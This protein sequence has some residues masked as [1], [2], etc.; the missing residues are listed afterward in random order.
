M[1]PE[2]ALTIFISAR[3]MSTSWIISIQYTSSHNISEESYKKFPSLSTSS[4]SRCSLSLMFP[5]QNSVH[6]SAIP[7]RATCLTHLIP[8]NLIRPRIFYEEYKSWT[9]TPC[10]FSRSL[11]FS[12]SWA[13][14]WPT[15]GIEKKAELTFWRRNFL[16]NFGTAVYK[17]RIIQEPKKVALWNKRHFEEEKTESMQHV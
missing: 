5:H 1:D 15:D 13:Q 12:P 7:I 16:L 17:M 14:M 11:W 6:T 8:L 9:P 2:F 10:H 3:R 4:S